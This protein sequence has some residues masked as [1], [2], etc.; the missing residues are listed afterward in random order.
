MQYIPTT[1]SIPQ[2]T[3]VPFLC[4]P[5]TRQKVDWSLV[6]TPQPTESGHVKFVVDKVVLG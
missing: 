4:D 2:E 1:E 6:L 5:I 3:H